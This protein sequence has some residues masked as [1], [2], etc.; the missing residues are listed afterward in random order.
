MYA[1]ETWNL[2]LVQEKRLDVI[3]MRWLRSIL[4]VRLLDCHPNCD[5]RL[6]CG[7][8][9]VSRLI[10]RQRLKYLGHVIRMDEYDP[11]SLQ[12]LIY[13]WEAPR[14]WSKPVGRPQARWLDGLNRSLHKIGLVKEVEIRRKKV[15]LDQGTEGLEILVDWEIVEVAAREREE[16]QRITLG[17]QNYNFDEFKTRI[18][19]NDNITFT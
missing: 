2:S 9:E 17:I 13:K 8:T 1:S 7:I 14:S 6:I 15:N 4:G 11:E 18:F 16:W 12:S 3:E 10:E 19:S 5:I